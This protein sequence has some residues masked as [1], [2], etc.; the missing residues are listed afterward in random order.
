M[1]KKVISSL[2][3]VLTNPVPPYMANV[4]G[5]RQISTRT[6]LNQ[7]NNRRQSWRSIHH[8]CAILTKSKK[9]SY[10]HCHDFI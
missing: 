9:A 3:V 4:P 2:I 1:L 8:T 5:E 10:D 6:N 7:L